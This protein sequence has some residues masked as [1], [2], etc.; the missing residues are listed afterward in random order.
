MFASKEKL[1]PKL[2]SLRTTP[3]TDSINLYA[4]TYT[5]LRIDQVVYMFYHHL[6]LEIHIHKWT[7]HLYSDILPFSWYKKKDLEHF[8]HFYD[9]HW[10]LENPSMAFLLFNGAYFQTKIYH[11]YLLN[12]FQKNVYRTLQSKKIDRIRTMKSHCQLW[13]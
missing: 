9:F 10:I 6:Y 7:F 4:T 1:R 13:Q 3:K 5:N 2:E 12:D 8:A 11:K